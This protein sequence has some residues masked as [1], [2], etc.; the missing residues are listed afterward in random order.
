MKNTYANYFCQLLVLRLQVAYQIILIQFIVG[1]WN[2]VLRNAIS[3]NAFNPILENGLKSEA[4]E[5]LLNYLKTQENESFNTKTLRLFES[6]VNGFDHKKLGSIISY[7]FHNFMRLVHL[8]PGFFLIRKLIQT[9][10][11]EEIQIML[12]NNINENL[13][14]FVSIVNGSLL[15]QSIIRNF[16]LKN[17]AN[18]QKGITFSEKVQRNITKIME[19]LNPSN[20]S[21]KVDDQNNSDDNSDEKENKDD[22]INSDESNT[23]LSLFYGILINRVLVGSL[24]KHSSKILE[25]ALKF[26][27]E[28]FHEKVLEKFG[29]KKVDELSLSFIQSLVKTER[30]IKFIK[31]AFTF[32]KPSNKVNFYQILHFA[33]MKSSCRILELEELLNEYVVYKKQSSTHEDDFATQFKIDSEVVQKNQSGNMHFNSAYS[34]LSNE[35]VD[36]YNTNNRIFHNPNSEISHKQQQFTK[37]VNKIGISDYDPKAYVTYNN[38]CYANYGSCGLSSKPV[39]L[40]G[41]NSLCFNQSNYP[42]NRFV[43]ND[44][45]T[46]LFHKNQPSNY[47]RMQSYQKSIAPQD[48][49]MSHPIKYPLYQGTNEQ[50]VFGGNK[51]KISEPKPDSLSA[52]SLQAGSSRFKFAQDRKSS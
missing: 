21:K 39:N 23:G 18:N 37:P 12:I 42:Y 13:D 8:R 33:Y 32:L 45:Q 48:K 5:F 6:I 44:T 30:G 35:Q 10:K 24:N 4:E 14:E 40:F 17:R 15:S 36:Y 27:G 28:C 52:A 3:F 2:S 47:E 19:S 51:T 25:T 11:N 1:G 9:S 26:G 38:Y 46:N 34:Q 29:W 31:S 16:S 22:A 50:C 7:I 49:K 20:K 43:Y 41:G